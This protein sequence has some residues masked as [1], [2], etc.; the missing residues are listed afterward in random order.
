MSSPGLCDF[1]YLL[2][3][4]GD[5]LQSSLYLFESGLQFAYHLTLCTDLSNL[6]H[7]EV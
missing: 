4:L 3:F 2:G 7:K 5:G 1:L 6:K